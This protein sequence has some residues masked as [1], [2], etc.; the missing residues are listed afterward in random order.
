[1]RAPAHVGGY[2][3]AQIWPRSNT[4]VPSNSGSQGQSRVVALKSRMYT[5]Q[6]DVQNLDSSARRVGDDTGL[7]RI[8]IR[9]R[10]GCLGKQFLEA[11]LGKPVWNEVLGDVRCG[12]MG[13]SGTADT[14]V[15]LSAVIAE[16]WKAS[17]WHGIMY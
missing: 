10:E 5:C 12:L 9:T 7:Q 15:H 17:S 3:F 16:A 14:R 1:M 2:S 8:D 11:M 13:G 6:R 4:R